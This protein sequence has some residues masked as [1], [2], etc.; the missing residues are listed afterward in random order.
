MIG[1]GKDIVKLSRVFHGHGATVE[2]EG[3][4]FHADLVVICEYY[5][6]LFLEEVGM[7]KPGCIA[8]LTKLYPKSEKSLVW[9]SFPALKIH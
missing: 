2:A 1:R 7:V 3:L 6:W 8:F 9:F 5:C 4:F